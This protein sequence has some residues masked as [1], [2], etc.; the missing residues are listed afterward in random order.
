MKKL[1]LL[2][3]LLL[4]SCSTP[5]SSARQNPLENY[6]DSLE[7]KHILMEQQCPERFGTPTVIK[8]EYDN[9]SISASCKV[10]FKVIPYENNY[11]G[12]T[13]IYLVYAVET[14]EFY[15]ANSEK[16]IDN[17]GKL[18]THQEYFGGK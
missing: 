4:A 3:A 6:L 10:M 7:A 16:I 2:A 13:T 8:L 15:F 18:L 12:E 17:D 9:K 5:V 14:N 11:N 1:I